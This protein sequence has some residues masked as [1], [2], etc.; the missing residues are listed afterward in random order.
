MSFHV[1]SETEVRPTEDPEKVKKAVTNILRGEVEVRQLDEWSGKIILEGKDQPS[2]ERFRMI[3]QRDRIRAAARSIL[4]RSVDGNR[5]VFYL[6]KQAAYAGHVSFSAPEGESPLGPI[7][8]IVET[9]NPDQLIDWLA[10][11]R[12]ERRGD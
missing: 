11:Q 6:N 5:L 2:L 8:V 9:G 12:E 3:L 1:H 4:R 7:H 10:G